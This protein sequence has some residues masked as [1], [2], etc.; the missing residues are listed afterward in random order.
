[1]QLSTR[2]LGRKE[3]EL[4]E[5]HAWLTVQYSAGDETGS[6]NR[7]AFRAAEELCEPLRSGSG[8]VDVRRVNG[9]GQVHLGGFLNRRTGQGQEVIDTFARIGRVAAGSY[10]VLYFR[11]DEDSTGYA[12]AFQI[13]VMRR[14][15]VSSI[16]DEGLSPCIPAIEDES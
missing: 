6:Q 3:K 4:F 10:G 14:G 8:L 11:D 16:R 15:M 13:L 1:M 5:Y 12:N 9:E 7:D 2:P